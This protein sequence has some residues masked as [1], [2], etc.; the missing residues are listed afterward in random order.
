M[1]FVCEIFNTKADFVRKGNSS[2]KTDK[3]DQRT[4]ITKKMIREA[5]LTLLSG[6]DIRHI[7]VRELCER[8]QINRGTFYKYYLDVYDLK[9]QIENEL[10]IEFAASVGRFADSG[11]LDS[12]S[13]VCRTVFALLKENSELCMILLGQDAGSGIIDKFVK[14]GHDAFMAF[15][16]GRFPNTDT[17]KL[18]RY[19]LFISGGCVVSLRRWILSGMKE[20]VEV[21][22]EE[23][24]GIMTYGV[25][26]LSDKKA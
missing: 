11:A 16:G 3:A 20:P 23:I 24:A 6:K 17:E 8:A 25:G 5:F 14:I 13:A 2:V 9:E 19:Y 22:A 18:E 1:S 15:Y 7:T 4:R 12:V 21:I 26:Y 10:L